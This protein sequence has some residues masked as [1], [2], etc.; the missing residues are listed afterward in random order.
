VAAAVGTGR[1]SRAKTT[2]NSIESHTSASLA[3]IDPGSTVLTTA[4]A[5]PSRF[6]EFLQFLQPTKAD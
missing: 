4:A 2:A 5:R 3:R 6:L 1:A